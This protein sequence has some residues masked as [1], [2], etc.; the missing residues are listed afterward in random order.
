MSGLLPRDQEFSSR[1][2]KIKL[3][4]QELMKWCQSGKVRNVH[5]L[6]PDKVW[7]KPDGRLVE[8]YYFTDFL[9]LVEEGYNKFAKSI[10]EA[11]VKV[12]QGNVVDL[13]EDRKR[14]R[15]KSI[16]TPPPKTQ[17]KQNGQT[18]STTFTKTVLPKPKPT[19]TLPPQ[20]PSHQN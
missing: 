13:V 8:R 16:S 2:D 20:L 11:I 5:Y 7:T 3:V 1:R 6:N 18:T 10:Y 14:S 12:S 4:N 9:H 19:A 17:Q 15:N